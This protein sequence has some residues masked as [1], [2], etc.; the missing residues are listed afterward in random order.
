M[1]ALI[2]PGTV[3]VAKSIT[4]RASALGYWYN[5]GGQEI[6]PYGIA[7]DKAL[8]EK[9]GL[10]QV[11]L[12][13]AR[14]LSAEN[15][16]TLQ[17]LME[18]L[19]STVLHDETNKL[20]L[21]LVNLLNYTDSSQV[22]VLMSGESSGGKSYLP[23]EIA[24]YFPE[25]DKLI[26]ASSSPT[27]FFHGQGEWR[28]E[29][30]EKFID[31]SRKILIFLDQPHPGLLEKL[32]SLLSHD[33]RELVYKIT[34]RKT[35]GALRT[36]N[37]R[38]RG[39]PTVT[40]C[41]AK[42][43][44]DE[45]ERTRC[46]MLSPETSEQKVKDSLTLI[47]AKIGSPSTFKEWINKHAQRHLLKIRVERIAAMNILDVEIPGVGKVCDAFLERHKH[48]APRQQRDYPRL[49]ALVKAHAILNAFTRERNGN[50]CTITATQTD[51]DA[52]LKLYDSIAAS[53]EIGL[54]PQ[55]YEIYTEVIAPLLKQVKLATRQQ[56]AKAY[57]QKY[58]RLLSEQRLRKEILPALESIGLTA[59]ESDPT[60]KRR[61]LVSLAVEDIVASTVI[62]FTLNG[63]SHTLPLYCSDEVLGVEAQEEAIL[64]KVNFE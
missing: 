52:A 47:S 12:L 25:A 29:A 61:M 42:M 63:V 46:F 26:I 9:Y 17:D 7:D 2:E 10:D 5:I 20:I 62:P 13:S 24:E 57:Y 51:I 3:E 28:K 31:L 64:D 55:L 1:S 37:I 6:G 44:A 54:S 27:S 45:Q 21:F 53:N 30:Q 59:E 15:E 14:N 11:W 50:P 35:S 41:T 4:A 38:I 60:D 39:F 36:K 33:Q 23:L 32:R 19:G 8:A 56:I 49:L 48:L 43:T 18:I 34:D 58:G 40:F 16:M 22:N